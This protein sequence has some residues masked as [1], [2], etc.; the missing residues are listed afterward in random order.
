MDAEAVIVFRREYNYYHCKRLF[1]KLASFLRLKI[2][3]IFNA[4]E[5]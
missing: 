3:G 4:K 5:K 1:F 2:L